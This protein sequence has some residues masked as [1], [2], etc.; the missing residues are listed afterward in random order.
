MAGISVVR[1]YRYVVCAD[2]AEGRSVLSAAR[3]T[4]SYGA[5]LNRTITQQVLLDK[6][7]SL[8]LNI[9][10]CYVYYDYYRGRELEIRTRDL[11]IINRVLYL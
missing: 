6:F 7:F 10:L 8:R 5:N 3:T 2:R 4:L 11:L 9:K 1:T